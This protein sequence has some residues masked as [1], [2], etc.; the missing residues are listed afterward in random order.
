M[1]HNAQSFNAAAILH[2]NSSYTQ[3]RTSRAARFRRTLQAQHDAEALHE[4]D[5]M[6]CPSRFVRPNAAA[7][8]DAWHHSCGRH[9][10][11]ED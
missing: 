11:V 3:V 7:Q 8:H 6:I 4:A 1:E 9:Y 5:F 10:V 2:C